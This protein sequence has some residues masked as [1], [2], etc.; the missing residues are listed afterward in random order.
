MSKKSS[1]DRVGKRSG[2]DQEEIGYWSGRGLVD[3]EMT[4]G[5]DNV[6]SMISSVPDRYSVAAGLHSIA[7][8]RYQIPHERT[9]SRTSR[10]KLNRSSS[11]EFSQ[12]I[13]AIE[14]I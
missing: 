9:R 12:G 1:R 14:L 7:S 8:Y 13:R 2:S 3:R 11:V 10:L 4:C 6:F 5:L